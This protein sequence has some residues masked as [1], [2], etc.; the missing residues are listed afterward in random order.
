MIYETYT[1]IDE[2]AMDLCTEIERALLQ[3]KLALHCSTSETID[4]KAEIYIYLYTRAMVFMYKLYLQCVYAARRYTRER[5]CCAIDAVRR[6]Q[7]R[8]SVLDR[9]TAESHVIRCGRRAKR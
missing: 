5:A 4:Y 3:I 2:F 7:A 9:G 6:A 8:R 1:D